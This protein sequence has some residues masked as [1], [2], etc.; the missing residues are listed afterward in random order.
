MTFIQALVLGII[1]GLTEF[2]PVSSSAHLILAQNLFHLSGP[3]LLPFDVIVHLGTLLALF[4]YFAKDL[5]PL[6]KLS[7]RLWVLIIAANVPTA[8]IGLLMKHWMEESFN[9]LFVT[10]IT[11]LMNSAILWSVKWAPK[12]NLKQEPAFLD[13]FWIGVAQGISILP[14]VSR[15][16]ATVTTALWLK[17]KSEEAVRFSF[18]IG[19]IPILGAAALE[20]P[21]TLPVLA[22]DMWPPLIIGFISSLILGYFSI[23]FLFKVVSRGKF[24]DFALYT[25]VLALV[26]FWL[27]R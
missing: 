18:F 16:G 15:S 11:L 22:A 14:G 19:I 7:R 27:A 24:H 21:D 6:P 25:F 26:C 20:L 13:S 5:L 23:A 8:V 3:I 4:I 17:V 9:S 2:L 10:A 1:Q 12:N